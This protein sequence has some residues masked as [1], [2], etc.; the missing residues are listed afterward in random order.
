MQDM[1]NYT[2]HSGMEVMLSVE[3]VVTIYTED[4]HRLSFSPGT[5]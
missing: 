1:D 2:Y 5:T 4:L 3:K